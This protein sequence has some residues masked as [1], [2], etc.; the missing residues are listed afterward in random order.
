MKLFLII[1]FIGSLIWYLYNYYTSKVVLGRKVIIKPFRVQSVLK[2][3]GE[4][5]S[6]LKELHREHNDDVFWFILPLKE[7]LKIGTETY[8]CLLIKPKSVD[9]KINK[10]KPVVVHVRG[11]N[12]F[13]PSKSVFIDWGLAIAK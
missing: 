10:R 13:T 7:P 5:E 9:D 6:C 2:Q 3:V 4:I 12:I 1:S 8:S 11:S